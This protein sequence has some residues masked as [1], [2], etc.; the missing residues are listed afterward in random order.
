MI[1]KLFRTL[2]LLFVGTFFLF[3]H[4]VQGVTKALDIGS[5]LQPFV[6]DYLVETFQD[7]ELRLHEPIPKDIVFTFDQPWEGNLSAYYT[8]MKVKDH[9]R[10]YY[11]GTQQNN[12]SS[13][14]Y[15][16][17]NEVTAYATSTDGVTWTRPKLN[18]VPYNGSKENNILF[19]G[20]PSHAFAPF[21]DANPKAKTSERFKA[22]GIEAR[23]PVGWN[24]A[25]FA[26]RSADG[27]NWAKMQKDPILTGA[28][29]DTLNQ[30][31][32]DS[33]R[34]QY[35]LFFREYR[36]QT[37]EV[38]RHEDSGF[39]DVKVAYSKDFLHWS[40]SY[41]Q[42]YND[43]GPLTTDF[44]TN[45]I[46]PYP[47]AP[48]VFFNIALRYVH[49]RTVPT[50]EKTHN[51]S[52]LIFLTSRSAGRTWKMW[53]RAFVRPGLNADRWRDHVTNM[54]AWGLV[55]TKAD[56]QGNPEVPET[57]SRTPVEWSFYSVE[58]Y[59]RKAA[60]LRRYTVRKDGF[61]SVTD[62]SNVT[63]NFRDQGERV[64]EPKGGE[65]IT[66]PLTFSGKRL[67]VNYSTSANGGV[68]V[69]LQNPDGTPLEG[70]QLAD[71]TVLF[72][73]HLAGTVTWQ[74]SSGGRTDDLSALAGKPIR[75]RFVLNDADLYALRFR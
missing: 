19:R 46:K 8:V 75:I 42:D 25:L 27:I 57:V 70:Y 53:K 11:R 24:W 10:L 15:S 31:F 48:S 38:W 50:T 71:S 34:K 30:A 49:G 23:G 14:P 52:D 58:G 67:I 16:E 29:F 6:D 59:T 66:K 1:R 73:D 35:V 32:W 12:N 62:T 22:V 3:P 61:V 44:Y 28:A 39:R 20:G 2:E 68:R 33:S 9:Y 17:S 21:Y 41:W 47:G 65:L 4:G 64:A 63:P 54:P 43:E 7:T 72:G 36:N 55:E 37:N 26:Y 40:D 45:N 5:R 60:R 51:Y 13:D 74:R 69:E 18:L 56:T